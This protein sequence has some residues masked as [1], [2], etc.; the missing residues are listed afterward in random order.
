[1][2]KLGMTWMT[3]A[4]VLLGCPEI[5]VNESDSATD[6]AAETADT[7][8]VVVSCTT[9]VECSAPNT[10]HEAACN[11]TSG[12]C[13]YTQLPDTCFVDGAC[14]LPDQAKPGDNCLVCSPAQATNTLLN[15]VC[16]NGGT[17]DPATG[18]CEATTDVVTDGTDIS[19]DVPTDD[20]PA[21]TS[22][23]LSSD[24]P[25][26]IPVDTP[27]DTPTDGPSDIPV[28]IT[29]D[30][31]TD[32]T[33]DAEPDVPTDVPEDIVPDVCTTC[34]CLHPGAPLC[35]SPGSAQCLGNDVSLCVDQGD[36]CGILQAE[37]C[38][39]TDA[40][41]VAACDPTGSL[42]GDAA[43][44]T[45]AVTCGAYNCVSGTGCPASCGVD[46]DCVT[47]AFCIDGGCVVGNP[48]GYTCS[49]NEDCLSGYCD[50]GLCCTGGVCC[51]MDS[52][53]GPSQTSA[54]D[55]QTNSG[56]GW[57]LGEG[58][59]VAQ[60]F[61]PSVDGALDQLDLWLSTSTPGSV[62]VELRDGGVNGTL[63]ATATA[64]LD[65]GWPGDWL[66]FDFS[67]SGATLSSGGALTFVVSMPSGGYAVFHN[68]GSDVV[69]GGLQTKYGA[70]NWTD[71]DDDT[72]FQVWIAGPP[73]CSA[74][75]SCQ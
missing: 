1:M 20:G 70:G 44:G 75:F 67:G 50:S 57:G 36:G 41:L 46:G 13:E 39:S 59:L 60:T 7:V 32:T 15:V 6:A 26:D 10:C 66:S 45:S 62:V 56:G 68:A 3:L 74:E 24:A 47:G 40:C 22:L 52:G 14:F 71:R 12:V 54:A 69:S 11:T 61:V 58:E 23:D 37:T 72:V 16:S 73:L 2:F 19:P 65:F 25:V 18:V 4:A 63:L 9:D 27:I 64:L 53:C 31:P 5:N 43:C 48:N 21:D 17:C 51:T 35:A 38:S 8:V 42:A 30:G 29:P 34:E 33:P 49:A 28:D 55:Q